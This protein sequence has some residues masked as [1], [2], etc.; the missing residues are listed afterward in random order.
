M[1]KEYENHA[2][3]TK[4]EIKNVKDKYD[5]EFL[6]T[7]VAFYK[8]DLKAAIENDKEKIRSVLE[9][10]A[11]LKPINLTINLKLEICLLMTMKI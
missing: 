3:Q 2:N 5:Q 4:E 8:E 9:A 7:A 6:E 1:D 11:D 10:A